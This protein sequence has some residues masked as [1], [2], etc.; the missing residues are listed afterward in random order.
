MVCAAG[1]ESP[2][3]GLLLSLLLLFFLLSPRLLLL[4]LP[5]GMKEFIASGFGKE[6]GA[7][8]LWRRL[9]VG[10]E[11]ELFSVLSPMIDPAAEAETASPPC[12]NRTRG[13]FKPFSS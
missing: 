12:P 6:N 1:M 7:V 2:F 3:L 11:L 9:E 8:L 5:A 13:T 4:L 10:R